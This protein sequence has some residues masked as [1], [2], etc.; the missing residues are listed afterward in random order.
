MS[1]LKTDVSLLITFLRDKIS[2]LFF[3]F[4]CKRVVTHISVLYFGENMK[5]NDTTTIY[6]NRLETW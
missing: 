6:C 1:S 5:T 3:H 2:L 4:D